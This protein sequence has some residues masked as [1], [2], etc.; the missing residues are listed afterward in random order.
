MDKQTANGQKMTQRS[1]LSA[2]RAC[3]LLFNL[4]FL[5]HTETHLMRMYPA[6]TR[7]DSSNFS[8]VLYWAC[9]IQM[10]ALNFQTDGKPNYGQ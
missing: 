8:P 9:G 5:T 6:G 2:Q 4:T 7:I 10:S 1:K 3:I